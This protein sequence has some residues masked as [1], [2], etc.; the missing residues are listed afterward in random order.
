[1]IYQKK[2]NDD[3]DGICIELKTLIN[4]NKSELN[5]K[6]TTDLSHIDQRAVCYNG[7]TIIDISHIE[8]NKY[9]L[10]YRFD[11]NIYNGCVNMDVNDEV[12]DSLCFYI[13]NDGELKFDFPIYEKRIPNDEL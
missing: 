13:N 11:Y 8:D 12:I 5:S 7:I 1:M 3:Q 6:I 2:L 9:L 4:K 10:E